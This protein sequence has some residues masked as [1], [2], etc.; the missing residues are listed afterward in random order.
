VVRT[1]GASYTRAART[2]RRPR[3]AS[4]S[5]GPAGARPGRSR[6][7]VRIT[8]DGRYRTFGRAVPRAHHEVPIPRH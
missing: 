7:G 2:A 4:R 8:L 1:M 3:R 6:Y 5:R